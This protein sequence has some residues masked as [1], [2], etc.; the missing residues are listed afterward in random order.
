MSSSSRSIDSNFLLRV[1]LVFEAVLDATDAAG[2]VAA[3][4]A[5][6]SYSVDASLLAVLGEFVDEVVDLACREDRLNASMSVVGMTTP[7]N[8]A[9]GPD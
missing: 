6:V 4:V 3:L 2:V 1:V 9:R 7:M 5:G 8:V